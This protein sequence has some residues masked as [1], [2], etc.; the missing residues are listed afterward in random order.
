MVSIE[1]RALN[2]EF[3]RG[4]LVLTGWPAHQGSQ[5]PPFMRW[6]DRVG[7]FRCHAIHYRALVRHCTLEGPEIED[8]AAD[9]PRLALSAAALPELH[10]YQRESL[11]AWRRGKRGMVELP[12]GSG[13]TVV[14]MH[15]I[16]EVQR[17]TLVLVPTLDLAAQWCA[18]LEKGLGA[19][20]GMIG[21]G[22]FDVEPLTV[23]T[24]AS[25][26]RHG[27]RLGA[28]FGLVIFDECHHLAGSGYAGIA[29]TLIAPYRLGIS[30]TLDRPGGGESLQRSIGP[31]VY[32]KGIRELSGEY[33]AGYE[34][35]VLHAELKPE[36]RKAY[37]AARGL[38]L[39]FARGLGSSVASP[40]GW[41]RFIFAAS[42]GEEGRAALDA[43]YRQ[44]RIAFAAEDKL[45]IAAELLTRHRGQRVLIFTNDNATAYEVSRRFLLPII[46][47][48]TPMAERR[49]IMARLQDGRWP[50]VVTSKVLNEG[51]D[52]PAAA[53]AVILSG[54]A[55]VREHVQRLGRV[56]RK[57]EGKRAVLYEILTRGTGEES[58]SERRRR[59]DAYR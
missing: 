6:D 51:V 44:R 55:S 39:D 33:L 11:A 25:A 59:H 26:F 37:L 50:A 9:Y 1:P 54:T 8:R 43:Y 20:P 7:A 34:V 53:V 45:R 40:E 56:L 32:H 22:C 46:T 10:P 29:E 58:I 23:C 2:L 35:R 30:A 36:E 19:A 12:T 52:V 31:L 38:Y 5:L 24:Y 41:R 18:V 49:E 48:Q 15:A 57:R 16:A 27:E 21:G 4:S 17:G 47:H 14:G 3:D 42:R 28:R 13:K